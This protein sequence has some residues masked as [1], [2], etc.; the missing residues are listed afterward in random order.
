MSNI[1]D[2]DDD[3]HRL[4]TEALARLPIEFRD[5]VSYAC[6]ER[7]HAYGYSEVLCH[8]KDM[9]DMLCPIIEEYTERIENQTRE[10]IDCDRY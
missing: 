8:V 1:D 4:E 5:A 7:G 3:F 10:K 9:V 6:Y 2:D